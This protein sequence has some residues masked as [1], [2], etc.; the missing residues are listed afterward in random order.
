MW[1]V[2]HYRNT[3]T[4]W[5]CTAVK[6]TP[7]VFHCGKE[8]FQTDWLN[9]NLTETDYVLLTVAKGAP[10]SFLPSR[11]QSYHTFRIAE[12]TGM[13][14]FSRQYLLWFGFFFWFYF[15][16]YILIYVCVQKY[17]YYIY[18]STILTI[19]IFTIS[20]VFICIFTL[21]ICVYIYINFQSY[22]VILS[23]RIDLQTW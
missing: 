2:K 9:I 3:I 11:Q 19:F 18:Y 4:S 12:C 20:T 23:T 14:P 8:N 7:Q 21:Y 15:Y 17:I 13:L 10:P 16:T 1:S 22:I 5:N 6:S